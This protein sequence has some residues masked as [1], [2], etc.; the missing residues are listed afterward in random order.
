MSTYRSQHTKFNLSTGTTLTSSS[1]VSPSS[2][3]LAPNATTTV[4]A[5]K[6]GSFSRHHSFPT[7]GAD[8]S[9]IHLSFEGTPEL[10]MTGPIST[11]CKQE[12]TPPAFDITLPHLDGTNN[13]VEVKFDIPSCCLQLDLTCPAQMML[14]AQAL[15]PILTFVVKPLVVVQPTPFL[16]LSHSPMPPCWNSPKPQDSH[17]RTSTSPLQLL[18][19]KISSITMVFNTS[20]PG[21]DREKTLPSSAA[22]HCAIIGRPNSGM[23]CV[24]RNVTLGEGGP[25]NS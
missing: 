11:T 12:I 8:P 17:I 25:H 2:C 22:S 16:P 20:S 10:N 5:F 4:Y 21:N 7:Y 18:L 14:V 1:S 9:P 19:K 6:V 24:R 23:H 13:H 15:S 3:I